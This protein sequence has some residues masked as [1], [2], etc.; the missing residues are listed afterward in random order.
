M[1]EMYNNSSDNRK[2]NYATLNNGYGRVCH[3]VAMILLFHRLGHVLHLV[4]LNSC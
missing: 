1:Y 2:R 4:P 3:S